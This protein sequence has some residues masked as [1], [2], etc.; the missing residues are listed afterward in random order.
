MDVSCRVPYWNGDFRTLLLRCNA[1]LCLNC[2]IWAAFSYNY[3]VLVKF[4]FSATHTQ[5]P[6]LIVN[7]VYLESQYSTG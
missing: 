4:L 1:L 5:L 6:Y 7:K 2:F 3:I